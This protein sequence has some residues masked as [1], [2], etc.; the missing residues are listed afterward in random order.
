MIKIRLTS[1]KFLSSEW[2]EQMLI[3]VCVKPEKVGKIII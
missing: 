1:L 3:S 2:I